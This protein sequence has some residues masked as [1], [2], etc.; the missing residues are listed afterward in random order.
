MLVLV[1]GFG[2]DTFA[3]LTANE[4]YDILPFLCMV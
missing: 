2:A 3:L 1:S 4:G